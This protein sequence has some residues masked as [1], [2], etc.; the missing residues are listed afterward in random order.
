MQ[1]L[2]VELGL[3][4]YPIAV[5]SNTLSALRSSLSQYLK[6]DIFIITNDVV[7]PLYLAVVLAQL[8]D[9][10]VEVFVMPDGEGEKN[11]TTWQ[12]ALDAL[13]AT[14]FSRD[15]TVL[16]LGGGVVG[17]LAGF[18]AASFHRGVDYIQLPTTL[19]AQVDSSVGGKTAVNHPQGKNLIGAFHQPRAVLIDTHCLTTLP[20]RQ[21]SAGLAE[22]I[23][24]G[25]M[26]DASFF[27]WLETHISDLLALES[28]TLVHA[29]MQ[30]CRIKAAV[31]SDD[32]REHGR[33]ALLNLGHTFGHAIEHAAGF[34]NWLHG[35]AVAA[36]MAIACD[37]AHHQGQL[38]IADYERVLALLRTAH[39]P[40]SAP[41]H[42]SWGTWQEL[43]LRDKKV[44]S[45]HARF[46]LPRGLGDAVITSD[47]PLSL[48]KD[49]VHRQ[50]G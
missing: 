31:V 36:G 18:V 37:I 39:L 25:I 10:Q 23:K 45:G 34:G 48:I 35:E 24:Y 13:M 49:A 27:S 50:R 21:R 42:M 8:E 41:A 3:R 4:S 38:C 6:H 22:I 16:A 28:D 30:S 2:I 17:D 26:A 15:C 40:V 1:Q 43:M 20:A 47:I 44:L 46:I 19:L 7:A 29:I 12:R 9:R 33:R 14:G 5:G 11:L 32:E